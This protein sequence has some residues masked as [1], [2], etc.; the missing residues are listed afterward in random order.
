MTTQS[1]PRLKPL[2]LLAAALL[3]SACGNSS[4]EK[5]MASAKT[6][7]EKGDAAAAI[8][9]VKNVLSEN[10]NSL[11][12]R[13]LL[14]KALFD[15]G[16]PI[17]AE[18][19]LRK[20]VDL[21]APAEQTAPLLAKILLVQGKAHKVIDELAQTPIA[22][23]TE[24]AD[25]KTTV[26]HSYTLLGNAE[27]ANA[28]FSEALIAKPDFAP[29]KLGLARLLAIQ[30]GSAK[31]QSLV[32]EILQKNPREENAWRFKGDLYR[33]ENKTAEA[34][35]AYRKVLE[36]TPTNSS[37]HINI[38]MLT[39]QDKKLDVASQQL[40]ELKKVAAKQPI[41]TYMEA[42]ITFAKN[43]MPAASNAIERFLKVQ[44]DNPQGLQ[45][46]GAIAFQKKS[47]VQAQ[48]YLTKALQKAPKL[49]YSRRLLIQSYQRSG[50]INKAMT[51]LQ[52]IL[53]ESD[54]VP[55]EWLT[56]AGEV[57]MRAGNTEQAAIYF[58]EAAKS[59]PQDTRA[60]TNLA[61][62]KIDQGLPEQA[63][64]NLA[65]IAAQDSGIAA[66]MALIAL[67]MRQKN[68]DK[69]ISAID[70]L[71]KKQ[72]N[73]P[74]V[75]SL[76]GQALLGKQDIA[77]ARKSFEQAL[78][79]DATYLPAVTS[80]V[81]LDLADNNLAQARKRY[82]TVI[83]KDPKNVSAMLSLAQ[84]DARTGKNLNDVTSLIKKAIAT[85]P[86]N[87]IPR[88]ALVSLLVSAK[89]K[90][91][92]RTAAE[93]ALAAFPEKPELLDIAGQAFQ[94]AGDN[95][96]A[97][98]SYN[99]LINLVPNNSQTYMRVAE[100]HFAANNKQS[101]RDSLNKGI[102]QLPESFPLK[103]AKIMLDVSEEKFDDALK[104]ARAMQTEKNQSALGYLLE[105]DIHTARKSWKE[106]ASAYQNGIK[107][108][109]N[110]DLTGRL[111]LTLLRNDQATEAKNLAD[112]WIKTHPKD[113]LFRMFIADTA[114]QRKDFATAVSQYHSI[115]AI[116]PKNPVIL[117][118]LAWAAGQLN[119]PKAVSYAE[120]ANKLAPNQPQ[121][122]ETL[123]SLYVARGKTTEGLS[124]LAKAVSLAPQNPDIKLGQAKAFI[125]VGKKAE[126]K[127]LLDALAKL[128]P[129]FGSQAE[130]AA[131]SKGL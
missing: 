81:G 25:L 61:L 37:V 96:Q 115:L 6:Y 48:A 43:D 120:E 62:S 72:P 75:H 69:A 88:F 11:E 102:N 16:D 17:A 10:P 103:R 86:A 7:L 5:N 118:N 22:N 33:A 12:A 77:G 101:A 52:P 23:P 92:A 94:L 59:N 107:V 83:A 45:L 55:L 111:Y 46:A 64:V 79:T 38:I 65:S 54:H 105:G 126:A 8:I 18:V 100:I 30:G 57:Y 113:L 35:S 68:F 129:Q 27:K 34:L 127:Q 1:F 89:E 28:L 3:L 106:A 98:A 60:K 13:L 125:K 87:P 73:S 15:S 20:A 63:A 78:S 2:A 71:A 51:A 116:T 4:P 47:D 76:R 19:E 66:D 21:K 29:A 14:S 108:S 40:E 41:T 42:V 56:L 122:L 97:L 130:V 80:L 70:Q 131:L 93:E 39:L 99:K 121:L 32:E 82:E 119:D 49:N 117:N 128:G 53:S 123:G 9:Q 67:A 24:L 36:I 112:S 58:E 74:M 90:E 31:A 84:L 50:Q 109:P 26:G 91:K 95:N 104:S 114:N 124:L 110:S 44:P 85:D